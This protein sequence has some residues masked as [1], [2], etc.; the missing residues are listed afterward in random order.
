MARRKPLASYRGRGGLLIGIV[1]YYAVSG[2]PVWRIV[3][4]AVIAL[5]TVWIIKWD[6]EI[7]SFLCCWYVTD[8]KDTP[9]Q[10]GL[11]KG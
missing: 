2:D 3:D 6:P 10:V 7:C 5:S 9:A 11:A 8:S 1:T 4:T